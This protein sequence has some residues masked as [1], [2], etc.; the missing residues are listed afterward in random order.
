M[1]KNRALSKAEKMRGKA[2]LFCDCVG[3]RPIKVR[4]D[5]GRVGVT[6]RMYKHC[7]VS[8]DLQ[9]LSPQRRNASREWKVS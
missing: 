2:K 1:I 9:D 8:T 3:Q 5:K 7:C 6:G 4:L